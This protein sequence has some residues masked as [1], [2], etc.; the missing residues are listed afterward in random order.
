[1]FPPPARSPNMACKSYGLAQPTVYDWCR[2]KQPGLRCSSDAN[3][4]ANSS[5]H[6]GPDL[7]NFHDT[8]PDAYC[9]KS[10]TVLHS[11]MACLQNKWIETVRQQ[12]FSWSFCELKWV[13][14][15][16]GSKQSGSFGALDILTHQ[17]EQRGGSQ[18][19]RSCRPCQPPHANPNWMYSIK[20]S[21]VE[22]LGQTWTQPTSIESM[23]LQTEITALEM[24]CL[25]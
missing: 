4:G 3:E 13:V 6:Q 20:V 23:L 5:V 1:M 17:F 15:R 14:S 7:S 8:I 22:A 11:I 2:V 16:S 10:C 24:L 19:W 25:F 12:S 9:P 21:M 18:V